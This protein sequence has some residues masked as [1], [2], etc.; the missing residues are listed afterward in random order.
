M[1]RLYSDDGDI[2]TLLQINNNQLSKICN[3]LCQGMNLED[4]EGNAVLLS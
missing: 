1:T 2:N 4:K 3:A